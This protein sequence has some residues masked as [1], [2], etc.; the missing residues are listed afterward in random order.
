MTA[1]AGPGSCWPRRVLLFVAVAVAAVGGWAVPAFA[2]AQLQ[3]TDPAS[4]SVLAKSPGTVV[5]HFGEDVEVQFG[6]V[7][8][9]DSGSHRVDT[10]NA[11]HPHGDGRA[12][13]I[14]VPS[15]LAAGGYVVTWRVISADSHPVHGAFTFLI[16]AGG[17]AAGATAARAQAARLLAA[18]GGS[19]TVG[20]LFGVVRFLAFATLFVLVG[21]VAFVV[22][23]WPDGRED[24]KT[25]TVI[26]AALIGAVATT[27]L[28]IA[29]QGPYGGG[30]ALAKVFSPA[31]VT[32]VLHTRFG[33][34]YVARLVVLLLAGF[35]LVRRLFRPEPPT[36]RWRGAAGAA[37]AA[38][39]LTP[40]VAGHAATGSLVVLAV[41]FDLVHMAAAAVWFGG[42][43]ILATTVLAPQKDRGDPSLFATVLPRYS[44]WALGA[45]VAIAVSGG[46][47]AWR[48]IGS[49]TAVTTT[50]F[51]RLV[52]AKTVLFVVVVAVATRSRRI[53]HG[54]LAVPYVRSSAPAPRPAVAVATSPG[55]GAMAAAPPAATGPPRVVRRRSRAQRQADLRRLVLIEALLLTAVI[56][57]A[58]VLVNTQPAR[59]ALTQPFATEVH[60][61]PNV[62][63]DVVVDPA[64]A[65]PVAV[66]LYTLSADGGQLNV[67]EVTAS[68]SLPSAGITNLKLPLQQ[69]GVG[70]FLVAGFQVPLR[71]TWK[72]DITVRTTEFDEFDATPINVEMR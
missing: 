50:P 26:L 44:Q 21:G 22:G 57:V 62:L 63:V 61:G 31:V 67:P 1:P 56:A 72:L 27:V 32:D 60:A 16:G 33:E 36:R 13:A 68:M 49:L 39:L 64:K 29:L 19:H 59:Q 38:L 23:A 37:G 69:A 7:R 48:Q 25:Q 55:P 17:S 2:H 40:G 10:G 5:L 28:A 45:V 3:S 41:P 9:F 24:R 52:V 70:H 30:L 58:A 71:G 66:H 54:R 43:A 14:N 65:G 35:P 20:V 6:A 34:V 12:V 51:G 15:N 8:V 42:L 4:G 46:F 11:Y 18:S 53:V 47:A